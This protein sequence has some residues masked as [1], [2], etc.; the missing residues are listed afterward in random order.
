MVRFTVLL[1]SFGIVDPLRGKRISSFRGNALLG[2]ASV[3]PISL[4]S[5]SLLRIWPWE[6]YSLCFLPSQSRRSLLSALAR[7]LHR[8]RVRKSELFS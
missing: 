5:P 2:R 7:S 1:L 4:G 6:F 3:F 8:I